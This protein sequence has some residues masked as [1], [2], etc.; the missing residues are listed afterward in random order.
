VWV[1]RWGWGGAR[2]KG[3]GVVRGEKAMPTITSTE[4]RKCSVTWFSFPGNE[5]EE[6]GWGGGQ[7]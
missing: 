6:T 3:R 1:V 7:N 4:K 2:R 5:K